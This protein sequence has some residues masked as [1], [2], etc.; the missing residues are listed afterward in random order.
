M[1]SDEAIF[2]VVGEATTGLLNVIT[3]SLVLIDIYRKRDYLSTSHIFIFH[4]ALAD[5]ATGLVI[6]PLSIFVNLYTSSKDFNFITCFSVNSISV[7]LENTSLIMLLCVVS[8][9]SIAIRFPFY[10]NSSINVTNATYFL[11]GVWAVCLASVFLPYIWNTGGSESYGNVCY[12]TAV[13]PY[14]YLFYINVVLVNGVATLGISCNHLYLS[15]VIRRVKRDDKVMTPYFRSQVSSTPSVVVKK[16]KWH[17]FHLF[18]VMCLLRTPTHVVNTLGYFEIDALWTKDAKLLF[19]CT[20][21]IMMRCN[22]VVNPFLY[23]YTHLEPRKTHFY[24]TTTTAKTESNPESLEK[25]E[26]VN[27]VNIVSLKDNDSFLDVWL[28]SLNNIF[29]IDHRRLTSQ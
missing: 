14:D 10:Y 25:A 17:P 5:I 3:N 26:K 2:L 7:M 27:F 28:V 24:R 8:D 6:S 11:L 19:I 13:I 16:R 12:F 9:R 20:A 22:S 23:A 1:V 18:L 29:P 21:I 15:T 4:L